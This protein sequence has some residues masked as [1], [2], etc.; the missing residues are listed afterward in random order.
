LPGIGHEAEAHDEN[1]NN[2]CRENSSALKA[3]LLP[4]ALLSQSGDFFG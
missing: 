2:D 3:D 1:N 4:F